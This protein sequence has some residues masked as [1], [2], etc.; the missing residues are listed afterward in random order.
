MARWSRKAKTPDDAPTVESDAPTTVGSETGDAAVATVD[1]RDRSMRLIAFIVL[2]IIAMVA[3]AAVAYTKWQAHSYERETAVAIETVQIAKDT[4]VQMLSY[5]PDTVEAD[6]TAV[7][8]RLTEG[9][10]EEYRTL[11]E[12]VVIPGSKEQQIAAVAEVPAAASM[13]AESDR[14]EVLVFVNQTV[15]IGS[16]PPTFTTSSVKVSLERYDQRW[17]IS[18]FEPI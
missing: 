4:T 1:R 17:L 11:T 5:Q 12:D 10:R 16:D 6:L 9:F 7:H 18:A 2:P 15:T 14:A 8:D 13:S 3:A